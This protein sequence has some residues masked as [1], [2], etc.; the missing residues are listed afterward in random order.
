[1]PGASQ[2][3]IGSNPIAI[4]NP[5]HR[6][7]KKDGS[8]L[9]YRWG[10]RRKRALLEKGAALVAVSFGVTSQFDCA[11]GFMFGEAHGA[12]GSQGLLEPARHHAE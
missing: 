4:L 12:A 3:A 2:E 7:V 6:V 8:I 5:C 11:P 10:V 1:M 9:G